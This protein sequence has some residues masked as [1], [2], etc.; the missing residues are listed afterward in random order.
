MISESIE[1]IRT[2]DSNVEVLG[3]VRK[4]VL[5]RIPVGPK[6]V[7]IKRSSRQQA[8]I[9]SRASRLCW[10]SIETDLRFRSSDVVEKMLEAIFGCVFQATHAQ[11]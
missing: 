5:P 10:L 7:V 9:P 4:K 6:L 8:C 3:C 2:S 11:R 1:E